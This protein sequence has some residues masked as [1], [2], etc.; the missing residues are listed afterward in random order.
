[1]KRSVNSISVYIED[2]EIVI[3][4]GNELD[5]DVRVFVTADQ[6]DQLVQ[7]LREKQVEINGT[8]KDG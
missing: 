8:Q 4:A 3:D 5:G 6:V 1:M 7:W 2:G